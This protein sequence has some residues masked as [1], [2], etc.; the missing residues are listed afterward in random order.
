MALPSMI[1]EGIFGL[2]LRIAIWTAKEDEL[3]DGLDV[4]GV[5]FHAAHDENFVSPENKEKRI[6]F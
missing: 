6:F 4:P 3:I 5:E 1:E 2:D